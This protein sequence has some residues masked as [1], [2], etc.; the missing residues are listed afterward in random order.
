MSDAILELA[1]LESTLRALG[2]KYRLEI[3][4]ALGHGASSATAL[5][6]ILGLPRRRVERHLA[7]LLDHHLVK[8]EPSNSGRVYALDREQAA[9]LNATFV[10]VVGRIDMGNGAGLAESAASADGVLSLPSAPEAC[11]QCHNASFVLNVLD[12][13]NESLEKAREYDVR[14]RQMSSQVLTAQEVERKRLSRELHDDTAQALTSVLVRLRVLERSADDEAT[15]AGLA[16]LRAILGGALEGVRALAIDL[17]PRVLDDLGLEMA[18]EAQVRDFTRR[19]RIDAKV[20]SGRLGRLATEVE[21]VLYRVAQEALSNVAKHARASRVEISLTKRGRRLRM[22]I[23]DDGCGF[24]ADAATDAVDGCLGLFGM[25][26]RLA[27]VGGTLGIESAV[28]AGTR[29]SADVSLAAKR[30]D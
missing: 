21:L 12:E 26:E 10:T 2:N 27:L 9:L 3:L 16:E 17:R 28:G 15:R 1:D 18:L 23:E 20:S 24:D 6:R 25:K 14:L 13:L 5:A 19:W 11:R 22:I 4:S 29:V 8:L 30:T 7:V